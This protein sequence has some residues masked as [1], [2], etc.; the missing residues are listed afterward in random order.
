MVEAYEVDGDGVFA[1]FDSN[2]G[3]GELL[4]GLDGKLLGFGF[5]LF[6]RPAGPAFD[7]E[8]DVGA[9]GHG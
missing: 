5:G 7:Y 2:R 9:A 3:W 6:D 4:A 8:S 1:A